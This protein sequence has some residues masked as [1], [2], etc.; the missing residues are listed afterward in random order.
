MTEMLENFDDS[1]AAAGIEIVS[2]ASDKQ[3]DVQV[4]PQLSEMQMLY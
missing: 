1:D 2:Q 4:N 3:G